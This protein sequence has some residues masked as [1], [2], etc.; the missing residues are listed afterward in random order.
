MPRCRALPAAHFRAGR[1]SAPSGWLP[2]L[3]FTSTAAGQTTTSPLR[4]CCGLP[5]QSNGNFPAARG[6][7]KRLVA[8]LAPYARE[9]LPI[10]ANSTSCGLMLKREAH[11]ILGVEDEDL[12]AVSN[13]LF[14]VCEFLLLLHD[15]GELRTDFQPLPLEVP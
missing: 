9:G 12:Q 2:K 5:L 11:E 7:V 10:V 3:S 15:Q 14:D 8:N 13:Q 1:A 4:A 6:Y